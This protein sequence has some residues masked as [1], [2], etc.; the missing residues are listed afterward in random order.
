MSTIKRC[1]SAAIAG[2]ALLIVGPGPFA[3]A[4][5]TT[6]LSDKVTFS[7]QLVP[8]GPGLYNIVNMNCSLVSDGETLPFDCQISGM[9]AS[10]AVGD[11]ISTTV[12]SA[13]GTTTSGATLTRGINSSLVGKG[14]GTEQDAPEPLPEDYACI[15]K[16]A[17]AISSSGVI[18]G[19]MKVKE[20]PTAP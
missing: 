9:F 12:T 2:S 4:G 19:T 15:A 6:V 16:Y 11:Q 18:F 3:T 13:D 8:N 10:S 5:A 14:R 1:L 7:A 17:V 20:S